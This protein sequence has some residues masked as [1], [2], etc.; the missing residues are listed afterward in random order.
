MVDVLDS[1]IILIIVLAL[2]YSG[3]VN[4]QHVITIAG[5]VALIAL[6]FKLKKD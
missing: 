5:I 4:G 1:M 2:I 3:F 6:I